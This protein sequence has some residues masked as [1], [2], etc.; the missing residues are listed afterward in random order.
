M[1]FSSWL[2]GAF[3]VLVIWSAWNAWALRPVATPAGILAP[4]DPLQE[5]IAAPRI[6][7]HGE[8]YLTQR[9][10]FEITARI[11]SRERY[12]FDGLA[13]LVPIDLALGWGPMSD[14]AMLAH[15]EIAQSGRFY[16]WETE[17]ALPLPRREITLHSTNL[18]V[19]PADDA[20]AD[21]VLRLRTGEVVHLGGELVDAER[22]DGFEMR[23][24]LSRSDSGAGACELMLVRQV[25]TLPTP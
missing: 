9:A 7:P 13:K 16:Y 22:D 24:S 19:I 23:T 2:K 3:V 5:P 20:I 14:S 18:H 17:S 21:R 4:D 15:F 6:V 8:Y 25:E 11:L 12:R 10:R 1:R